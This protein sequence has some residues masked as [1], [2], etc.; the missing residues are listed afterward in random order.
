MH[1]HAERGNE[2][3]NTRTFLDLALKHCF[4][5]EQLAIF[6][7]ALH[8]AVPALV[9]ALFYRPRWWQSY[10]WL[11]AGLVI[12]ID[13]LLAVPIYDPQRCSIGFHPFH[14]WQLLPVYVLLCLWPR[15]R[16]LG[17]GVMLHLLL[18]A[19]DCALMPGGLEQLQTFWRVPAW[20]Q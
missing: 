12:D 17:Y 6:H 1:S 4:T 8:L 11:L 19:G 16:L 10:L 3:R 9:V 13:H 5:R 2:K 15:T 18:D 14:T 7:I 20:M